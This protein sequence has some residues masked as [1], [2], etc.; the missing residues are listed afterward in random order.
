MFGEVPAFYYEKS[1]EKCY[2]SCYSEV[3]RI[4]K[5]NRVYYEKE[6]LQVIKYMLEYHDYYMRYGDIDNKVNGRKI[7]LIMDY[8]SSNL[9]NFLLRYPIANLIFS[10]MLIHNIDMRQNIDEYIIDNI[11]L[12]KVMDDKVVRKFIM[13][14]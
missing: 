11:N 8:R 4:R 13:S 1:F 5:I 6:M 9:A 7:R 10:Y 14:K 12:Y 2:K 3:I